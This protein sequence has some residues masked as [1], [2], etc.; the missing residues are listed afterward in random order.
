MLSDVD[1]QSAIRSGDIRIESPLPILPS[2]WQPVSVDLR[3]GP[4]YRRPLR[5]G[6]RDLAYTLG[7]SDPDDFFQSVRA[8]PKFRLEPG[9]FAIG[10]TIESVYVSDKISCRIEGKSSVGRSGLAIHVTA[11]F[12]DPGFEGEL[13]LELVNM[14]P[15]EIV[16]PTGTKVCQVCFFELKTPCQSPYGPTR[17][18]HYHG[19]RGPTLVRPK[20]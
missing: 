3:I 20:V 7:R 10:S 19:Q 5:S 9:G 2:Q 8:E 1:I 14:A 13:T 17:G 4:D 12:V 6:V 15:Y 16:I 18:S 11:G